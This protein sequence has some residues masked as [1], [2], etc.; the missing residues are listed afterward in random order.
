MM[1]EAA[2][3][4]LL[5]VRRLRLDAAAAEHAAAE[6]ALGGT[7]SAR[8][9]AQAALSAATR[10]HDDAARGGYDDLVGRLLS[11]PALA[12][13]GHRIDRLS[14]ERDRAETEHRAAVAAERDA[15]DRARAAAARVARARL[16]HD[17]WRA[18]A[19]AQ[20][21]A[22]AARIAARRD[23]DRCGDQAARAAARLAGRDFGRNGT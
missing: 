19:D 17:D 18:L 5:A 23:D 3:R 22:R 8:A 15:R 12:H 16:R 10:A 14:E 2:M 7:R 13:V 9:A 11:G 21:R 1:G 6:R 20:A 4:G